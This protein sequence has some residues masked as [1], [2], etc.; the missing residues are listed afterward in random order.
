MF[1]K[2]YKP[3][4][5]KS[6][7]HKD[8]VNHIRKW[9]QIIEE[10]SNNDQDVRKILFLYG[11]IGCGKSITVECLFKSYNLIDIDADNLR[12]SD[13]INESLQ[14]AVDFNSKTLANIEKWNHKNQREKRNIM[15]VDNIEL[16]ERSIQTFVDAIYKT[17]IN[18]PIILVCNNLKYKDFFSNY[19]NCTFI[20]FKQPSLLEMT[21]L[22][23]DINKLEKLDLDK[24]MIR[25]IIDKSQNDIRQILFLL[26]QWNISKKSKINFATFIE[27]IQVKYTDQDLSSKMEYLFRPTE[28]FNFD[29]V[30]HVS[31][32]EP[33]LVSNTIFQNYIDS[34]INDHA[35]LNENNKSHCQ[36]NNCENEE[37][38]NNKKTQLN[39]LENMTKFMDNISYSNIIHNEIYEKQQWELYND[40][41]VSSCVTP[42]YYL[43]QNKID[44][45]KNNTELYR[46]MDF[47]FNS[48]RDISY[49]FLNSY[50]EV[51]DICNKNILCN[52]L[53]GLEI[54]KLFH[55]ISDYQSCFY[56]IK[57]ILDTISVLNNY[58]NTNK[59]GKNTTKKE[60]LELCNNITDPMVMSALNKLIDIVYN[61]KL[62]EVDIDDLIINRSKYEKE[63]NIKSNLQKVDLRVF[64][65]FLNIFTFDDSHKI[66]KSNVEASLQYKILQRVMEHI[67]VTTDQK[68]S[69]SNSVED[70]TVDLEQIWSL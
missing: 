3:T 12:S 70:M 68:I 56:M 65:R 47:H 17:N 53:N 57:I 7:F 42:T 40:F 32:S 35:I 34:C 29:K 27:S 2:R 23:M 21:K 8:I 69:I 26:E 62:F 55:T 14:Q 43:K 33:H 66:F 45:W 50:R 49:N 5:Q 64:K 22:I 24:D 38:I 9:I 18:V 58:F 15:F 52:K 51:K 13:K 61:Y 19:K 6:L 63:E 4:T 28:P 44:I 25:K 59:R 11:P 37:C 39:E 67:N 31:A 30:Y 36:N 60:K 16:C 10:N 20:E 46:P 1:S 54:K 48:Y 41:I